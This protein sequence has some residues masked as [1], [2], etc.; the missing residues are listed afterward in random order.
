MGVSALLE[1]ATLLNSITDDIAHYASFADSLLAH[2]EAVDAQ[3]D[4][5]NASFDCD[6]TRC[7]LLGF[8]LPV[9]SWVNI[10]QEYGCGFCASAVPY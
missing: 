3:L 7:Q 10:T 6:A 8:S 4:R 1:R 5:L 9:F 2:V